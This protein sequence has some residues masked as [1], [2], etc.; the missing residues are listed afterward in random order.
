MYTTHTKEFGYFSL[1]S[2]LIL[3]GK[4]DFPFHAGSFLVDI[5]T[6]SIVIK[7]RLIKMGNQKQMNWQGE[8]F[9]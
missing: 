3:L 2:K 9:P 6:Q 1:K 4:W 8:S 7:L 5:L